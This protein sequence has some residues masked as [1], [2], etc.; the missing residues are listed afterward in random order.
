MVAEALLVL[1]SA[2]KPGV[3]TDGI[4]PVGGS[5]NTQQGR[6]SGV[7]RV[8]ELSEDALRVRQ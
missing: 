2:V 6:D 4:G 8:P 5:R 3:T 7:Q 1:K